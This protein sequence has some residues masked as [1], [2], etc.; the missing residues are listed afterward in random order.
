MFFIKR[1]VMKKQKIEPPRKSWFPLPTVV[2]GTVVDNKPNY[3][4]LGNF[5]LMCLSPLTVYISMHTSHYTTKGVKENQTFSV[6]IPSTNQVV[7]TD[8]VGIVSGH[9]VDKSDVFESFFGELENVPMTKECPVSMSCKVV[10]QFS[11]R[12]MDVF[13]GEVVE[14]FVN[15]D[16]FSDGKPD[17]E[18][19]NPLTLFQDM[20]YRVMGKKIAKSFHIGKKYE[21]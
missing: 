17:I 3:S 7:E 21:K 16:C 8:Y 18:K 11:V 2:V 4:T 15:Q 14:L 5:G 12:K 13:V 9:K 20:S 10:H 1:N 19:I 6:N